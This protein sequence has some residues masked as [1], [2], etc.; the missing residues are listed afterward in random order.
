MRRG[1]VTWSREFF[2]SL[3][4]SISPS[5]ETLEVGGITDPA[6][7][8]LI[9]RL[10]SIGDIVHALP[11]A[12]ALAET[13][14]QAQIHWVV[15]RR[16]ALLLHGNPHLH[17]I[18]ILDTLGW[19]KHLTSSSTWSEISKGVGDLRQI[20]YDAALDFQGLWKSAVVALVSRA[21]ERIGFSA[22]GMREPSAGIL[23]SQ[24][25]SPPR[26]VHVVEKN[27]AMVEHLGARTKRWQFPLPRNEQDDA[28]VE[29]ELATFGIGSFIIVHPGG[30]WRTK[31]WAPE[32]YASLI[33]QWGSAR[34]EPIL[35]T[36]SPSEAP[37]IND[38]LQSAGS[39]RA[40]YFPTTIVQFI[41][42]ARRAR[43]FIGGDTGPMHLAAAVGT[44]IVGIFGPTDPVRNGPFAA[45]DISLSNLGP[46]NHTRRGKTPAYLSGVSVESVVAATEKRL[47][48]AHG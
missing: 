20:R 11:A 17:R 9:V 1:V 21:Q 28:Y 6:Q 7:R 3:E 36:G 30:G 12:A 48:R 19:R 5:A 2:R 23:Y 42:L 35:L 34:T 31:C 41:A 22:E 38:I 14:P 29:K 37:V 27:L 18:L 4:S 47:A 44:P 25:V 39:S 46:I 26:H 24:R 33:R 16:H 13:F 10:S 43:L 32:N 8:F 15:E 45:D 40:R